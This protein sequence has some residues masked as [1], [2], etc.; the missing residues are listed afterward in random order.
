M[1]QGSRSPAARRLFAFFLAVSAT[2]SHAQLPTFSSIF[3]CAPGLTVF[4]APTT[5]SS[6]AIVYS[7]EPRFVI[8]RCCKVHG[9]KGRA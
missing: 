4:V 1:A 9:C 5:A 8:I 6:P 2:L 7:G 3:V